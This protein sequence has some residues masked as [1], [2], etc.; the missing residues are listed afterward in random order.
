MLVVFDSKTGNVN[1][2]IQALDI[3]AIKI[4]DSLIV[5][6]PYILVTYTTGFGLVPP[7]TAKFL[8]SNHIYLQGVAASGNRNWGDMFAKSADTISSR[9]GVPIL[10]KF[11]M[12]G[13]PDDVRTF[14]ERV[15]NIRYETH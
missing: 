2:F 9:Y 7:S 13:M 12:S 11:E 10:H 8:E 15:Q 4:S 6:E 14:K 1:R 5:D 3:E